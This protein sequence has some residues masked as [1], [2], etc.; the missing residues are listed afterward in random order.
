MIAKSSDIQ[1]YLPNVNWKMNTSR[2]DDFL[3]TAQS[4]LTE[5]VL[6]TDLEGVLEAAVPEGGTDSHVVLR[7]L[8]KRVLCQ[9]AFLDAIPILDL[10]LSEAGFV[11]HAFR[12]NHFHNAVLRNKFCK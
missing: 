8:V 4:E 7:S 12:V 5:R 2:L 9:A 11:V 3:E 10:Q 1:M 6:G